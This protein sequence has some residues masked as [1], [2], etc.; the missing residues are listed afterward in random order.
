MIAQLRMRSDVTDAFGRACSCC[1]GTA[2][3]PDTLT[4]HAEL[5]STKVC[6]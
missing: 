6:S 2:R 4:G 1:E 5:H 3:L